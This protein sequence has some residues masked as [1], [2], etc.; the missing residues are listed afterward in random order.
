MCICV[1]VQS[2]EMNVAGYQFAILDTPFLI[3]T[4]FKSVDDFHSH[5]DIDQN[6]NRQL[7]RAFKRILRMRYP[8]SKYSCWVFGKFTKLLWLPNPCIWIS[9]NYVLLLLLY[10]Y[11][12]FFLQ[13]RSL[14]QCTVLSS[15]LYRRVAWWC[16][17]GF[18]K[19]IQKFT[20]TTEFDHSYCTGVPIG[21]PVVFQ[22]TM[23]D[24]IC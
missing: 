1:F 18:V 22:I 4:G 10:L 5:K 2:C 6:R 11:T 24:L 16:S 9:G 12:L 3:H 23:S 14:I 21:T 7:Y 8:L 13:Q 17:F 20:E 15:N 19:I